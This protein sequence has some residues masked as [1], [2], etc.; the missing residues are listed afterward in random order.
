M[1]IFKFRCVV[2]DTDI[3]WGDGTSAIF[4]EEEEVL[5]ISLHRSL[6]LDCFVCVVTDLFSF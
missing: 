4:R 1:K 2:V 6:V 3:H 5:Y